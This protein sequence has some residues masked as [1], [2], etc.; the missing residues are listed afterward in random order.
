VSVDE[1]VRPPRPGQRQ[2]HRAAPGRTD[3][4]RAGLARESG[5]PRST[6]PPPRGAVASRPRAARRSEL[7][8]GGS[9]KSPIALLSSST[10]RKQVCQLFTCLRGVLEDL[11]FSL[12]TLSYRL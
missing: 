12:L 9:P 2:R 3:G 11:P 10:P 5:G 6:R 7:R 1:Q 8:A 4:C